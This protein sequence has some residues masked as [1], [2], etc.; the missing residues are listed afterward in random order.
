M[1]IILPIYH[2]FHIH[3]TLHILILHKLYILQD[4]TGTKSYARYESSVTT[5]KPAELPTPTG[6]SISGRSSWKNSGP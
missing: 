3:Y 1:Y 2:I 6:C 5:Y 4:A